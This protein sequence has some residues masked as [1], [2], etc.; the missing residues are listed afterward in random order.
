M[1]KCLC[2]VVKS[3]SVGK[4]QLCTGKQPATADA[5]CLSTLF[6]SLAWELPLLLLPLALTLQRADADSPSVRQVQLAPNQIKRQLDK[7]DTSR[8][9]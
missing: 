3:E 5:P 6:S 2:D 1:N 8:Q 9:D 4:S 7:R